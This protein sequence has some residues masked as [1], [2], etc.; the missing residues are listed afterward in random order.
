MKRSVITL[1]FTLVFTGSAFAQIDF[2]PR[3]TLLTSNIRI[4]AADPIFDSDY[5]LGLQVGLFA[6]MKV[7][8]TQ[9]YV[10]PEG[11]YTISG[12]IINEPGGGFDYDIQRLD[13]P[14]LAGRKLG[15]VR[16]NAGPVIRWNLE[17]E[18]IAPDGTI[19]F[20]RY[21]FKEVMLGYQAGVGLEVMKFVFDLKYEGSISDVRN[22]D[23][24]PAF[25]ATTRIN[26]IILAV[27]YK[28]F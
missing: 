3:F 12:G 13:F 17:T 18:I 20:N 9:W 15:P 16:V 11:L 4:P 22:I 10:Q 8:G 7:P 21:A 2:G 24:T 5:E 28:L 1:I 25:G 19:S 26:Q 6:R 23:N 14:V 27:G